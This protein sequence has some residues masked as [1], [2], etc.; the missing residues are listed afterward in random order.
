MNIK[1][2]NM[3]GNEINDLQGQLENELKTFDNM[4]ITQELNLKGT[5]EGREEVRKK[6]EECYDV[7]VD[8]LNNKI[9]K[10]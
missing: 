6:L 8:I 2:S 7:Q 3:S 9:D 5:K 10:L 4:I 1:Y